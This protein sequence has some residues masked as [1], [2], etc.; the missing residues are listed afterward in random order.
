MAFTIG[1]VSLRRALVAGVGVITALML[2][3]CGGGGGSSGTNASGGGTTTTPTIS[4][5]LISPTTTT[6]PLAAYGSTTITVQVSS[7]GVADATPVTVN[8]ASPCATSGKA[9][10]GATATTTNGQATVS[11]TDV[12]CAATDAITISTTG[13]TSIVENLVVAS[14]LAAALQFV[15]ASP[16]TDSIVIKGAGGNGRVETAALTF[17]VVDTFGKPLPNQTVNF[18]LYPAGIVTLQ[19]PSAISDAN[20][21]VV[22]TVNSGTTATTFRVDASVNTTVAGKATTLTTESDSIIVTTGQTSQI[23]F[24]LDAG[25]YNI[26]GWD[27]NNTTTN[28]DVFL[29]D[30]NGNPVADGTPVVF[31]TDSG[32]VGSSSNG[33]CVTANGTC[34]VTFRSQNPRY[35][36]GALTP[37]AQ[38]R[39]GLA[40]V[41][42]STTTSSATFSGQ[43][44][45][46]QSG[47]FVVSTN[48]VVDSSVGTTSGNTIKLTGCNSTGF[49]IQLN[50]LNNNP[51]PAGTTITAVATTFNTVP[52][53]VVGQVFPST[54]NNTGISNLHDTTSVLGTWH[55]IGFSAG[56]GT[57]TTTACNGGTGTKTANGEID[58]TVTTPKGDVT[59]VPVYLEYPY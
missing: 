38:Q 5:S 49:D 30:S 25:T 27:W 21:K 28:V 56:G 31:T 2:N 44:G 39:A 40:I 17:E 55:G 59:V 41:T 20:G 45:I 23:S 33:G 12:G 14:P 18:T 37:A 16:T 29:A 58:L 52:T 35:G 46:F 48:V 50:D 26:E 32:A 11:Y 3:A 9:K 24:T 13:A 47:S 4:L 51:M 7:N 10:L 43:I 22:A 57:G 15:S 42:A 6:T 53:A 19:Q 1:K 34:T 36:V 54:V 8:F